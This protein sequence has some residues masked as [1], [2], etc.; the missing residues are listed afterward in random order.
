MG[1]AFRVRDRQAAQRVG[2]EDGEQHVVH[3]DPKAEHEHDGGGEGAVAREQAAGEPRV[4]RERVEPRQPALIAMLFRHRRHGAEL[5]PRR[6]PGVLGREPLLPVVLGQ[7]REMRLDFLGEPRLTP[8]KRDQLEQTP[9]IHTHRRHHDRSCLEST[10][11]SQN[12]C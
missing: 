3:P 1:D 6:K 4:E 5:A 9:Q 10:G 12:T 7:Q 8:P 11:V 2:V